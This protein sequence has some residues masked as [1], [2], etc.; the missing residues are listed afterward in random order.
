MLS[1]PFDW[2]VRVVDL[3]T[4]GVVRH[5]RGWSEQS[6]REYAYA[7]NCN[8]AIDNGRLVAQVAKC[9]DYAQ[10]GAETADLHTFS[11]N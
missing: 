5:Y 6:A 10:K 2:E 4:N 1:F 3:D 7:Y 9:T 8:E 11:A